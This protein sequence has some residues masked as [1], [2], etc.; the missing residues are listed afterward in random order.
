M[1]RTFDPT[2]NDGQGIYKYTTLGKRFYAKKRTEYVVRVP[3]RFEGQRANGQLYNRAGLFPM[4]QPVLVSANYTE[5]QRDAY[6]K[7][8]VTNEIE[9]GVLAEYSEETVEYNPAGQ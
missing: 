5:A 2:Q 4:H 7:L 6:I 1:V 9:D 3:A 8:S